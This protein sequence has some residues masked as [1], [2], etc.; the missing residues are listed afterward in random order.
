MSSNCKYQNICYSFRKG[1][2]N[3]TKL[4]GGRA[5]S[6]YK[7]FYEKEEQEWI[8]EKGAREIKEQRRIAEEINETALNVALANK[9]YYKLRRERKRSQ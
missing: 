8:Y 2:D 9:E 1:D 6:Y 3:C 5:C 4:F 7:I